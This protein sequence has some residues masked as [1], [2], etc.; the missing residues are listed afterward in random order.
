[1]VDPAQEQLEV[2]LPDGTGTLVEDPLLLRHRVGGTDLGVAATDE[3]GVVVSPAAD[4]TEQE[5][6]DG[7]DRRQP[8]SGGAFRISPA[9]L[10]STGD[11]TWI[12]RCASG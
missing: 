1:M 10:G 8:Q 12:P 9:R 6:E 4:E 2:V 3:R 7:R 5:R 11:A